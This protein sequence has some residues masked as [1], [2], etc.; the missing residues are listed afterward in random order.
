MSGERGKHRCTQGGPGGIRSEKMSIK[1][2]IK[3]KEEDPPRFSDSPK[4]P[5]KRI[6]PKPQGPLPPPPSFKLLCIYGG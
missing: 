6:W 4:Y 2:A 5:L 1:T 3:Q